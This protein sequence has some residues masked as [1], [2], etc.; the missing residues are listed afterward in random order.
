MSIESVGTRKLDCLQTLL[1][2]LPISQH[3]NLLAVLFD[4]VPKTEQQAVMTQIMKAGPGTD[5]AAADPP[6]AKVTYFF[7][8]YLARALDH[9]GMGAA[10]LDLLKPWRR[11]L[12]LGL[13]PHQSILTRRGPTLMH[14][15]RIRFTTYRRSLPVFT[16]PSLGSRKFASLLFWD[17]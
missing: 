6:L 14:G 5:S 15:A 2:N 17:H 4:V 7:Q 3:A 10:Y 11:M 16:L 8:F 9:A 13:R 1:E 12:A